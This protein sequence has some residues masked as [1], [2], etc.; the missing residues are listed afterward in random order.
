MGPERDYLVRQEWVNRFA[1]AGTPDEVREKVKQYIAAGIDELTIV[2]CG[3]SKQA[4]LESFA[5]EVMEK[6]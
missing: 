5:R 4:T 3:V 6:L 1:L 2:P